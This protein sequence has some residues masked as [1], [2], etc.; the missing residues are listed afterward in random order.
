MIGALLRGA[1]PELLWLAFDSASQSL[2]NVPV[3]AHCVLGRWT[4]AAEIGVLIATV[5]VGHNRHFL[6]GAKAF[7]RLV[8]P[9]SAPGAPEL[10]RM[11]SQLAA[12]LTDAADAPANAMF[13]LEHIVGRQLTF[14]GRRVGAN[15][16]GP[17]VLVQLLN[18][19]IGG[20]RE[21]GPPLELLG[22]ALMTTEGGLHEQLLLLLYKNMSESIA[23][24]LTKTLNCVS[25]FT[26]W[27]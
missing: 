16:D 7:P 23:V 3:L 17:I 2:M 24:P 5:S 6:V 19:L 15:V 8:Q 13:V 27:R 21:V 12:L 1:S 10:R 11:L 26:K 18:D 25:W 22:P 14:A 20:D 9:M 4:N